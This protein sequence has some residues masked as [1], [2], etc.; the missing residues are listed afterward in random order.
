[1]KNMCDITLTNVAL[2]IPFL[3]LQQVS[4]ESIEYINVTSYP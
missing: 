1:M 2:A 3:I 4:A